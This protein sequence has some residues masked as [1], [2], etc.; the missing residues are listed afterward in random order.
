MLRP[1]A[2]PVACCCVLL[3]VVEPFAYHC[4]RDATTHNII[5]ATM[6]GVVVSSKARSDSAW[7]FLFRGILGGF[8]G[9][10]KE[11]FEF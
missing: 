11:F 6:L 9:S 7:D 3:G 4:N 5:G 8:V 10:L 1:F 2:H